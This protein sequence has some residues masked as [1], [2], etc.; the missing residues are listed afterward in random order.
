MIPE[1]IGRLPIITPLDALNEDSLVKILTDTKD[2]LT[3]QYQKMCWQ[4]GVKLI[5]TNEALKEIAK[6]AI[7]IGTGA[8]G[9]RT[10]MEN[11]MIDIMF[12]TSEHNGYSVYVTKEV[13]NGIPAQFQKAAA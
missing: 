2:A 4:D 6:K 9:L 8:R 12:H 13:V 5:F 7:T 10:V 3:K 11:F 1:L